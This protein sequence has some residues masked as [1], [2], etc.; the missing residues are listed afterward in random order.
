MTANNTKIYSQPYNLV[1]FTISEPYTSISFNQHMVEYIKP[2]VSFSM[3]RDSSGY[4]EET[5]FEYQIQQLNKNGT[6]PIRE[7]DIM[8]FDHNFMSFDEDTQTIIFK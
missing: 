3:A 7:S 5:D 8:F 6:R 2:K 1:D 4:A